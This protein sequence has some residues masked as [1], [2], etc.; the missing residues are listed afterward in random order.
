MK[1]VVYIS[2]HTICPEGGDLSTNIMFQEL[3]CTMLYV[4]HLLSYV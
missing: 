1:S 4:Y 2:I 3:L